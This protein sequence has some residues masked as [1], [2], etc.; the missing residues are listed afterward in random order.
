MNRRE[1][2]PEAPEPPA[3]ATRRLRRTVSFDAAV[4]ER[5]LDEAVRRDLPSPPADW[6]LE[7]RRQQLL[8]LLRALAEA[9]RPAAGLMLDAQG[10]PQELAGLQARAAEFALAGAPAPRVLRSIRAGTPMDWRL[11][12]AVLVFMRL[13]LGRPTLRLDELGAREALAQPLLDGQGL[14]GLQ[15]LRHALPMASLRG[16]L[17]K[18]H[19]AA[20]HPWVLT[21][22]ER[23]YRQLRLLR[24]GGRLQIG[25]ERISRYVPVKLAG[26]ERPHRA[27]HTYEWYEWS[28]FVSARLWLRHFD[29]R[30][31]LRGEWELPLRKRLDAHSGLL[32]FEPIDEQV[33][34]V[35]RLFAALAQAAPGRQPR[36]QFEWR[37][38]MR[39]NPADR[40][41]LVSYCPITSLRVS[42][43]PPPAGAES[44]QTSV[45]DSPG[46]LREGP[47]RWRLDRALLPREVLAIRLRLASL[48]PE[49]ALR[50]GPGG[51]MAWPASPAPG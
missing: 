44:I 13:V 43:E 39:L 40:D 34:E 2:A 36:C 10:L 33:D 25:L 46:L 29:S 1:E 14:G 8:A 48:Q 9:A 20:T 31:S 30:G 45:G 17:G 32:V 19:E 5:L 27:A 35:R 49:D 15:H 24:E 41:L 12:Q 28:R 26:F 23:D 7:Q 42:C 51:E 22:F 21:D 3:A 16:L 11:A 4:F 37:E 47:N 50:L 18:A 38:Q 6:A